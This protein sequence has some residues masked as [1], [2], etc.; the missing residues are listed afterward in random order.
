MRIVTV[1]QV[2]AFSS[3][4]LLW[5]RPQVQFE[6]SHF[7]GIFGTFLVCV[8]TSVNHLAFRFVTG[9]VWLCSFRF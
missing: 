1:L 9:A 4:I 5:C 2:Q 6:R 7:I 8:Q 3:N